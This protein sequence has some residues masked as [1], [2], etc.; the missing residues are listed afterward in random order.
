MRR[1][2]VLL[3]AM[4]IAWAS[5]AWSAN[6]DMKTLAGARGHFSIVYETVTTDDF[7]IAPAY[8]FQRMAFTQ[9]STLEIEVFA[10]DTKGYAAA[11]CESLGAVTAT[12]N[13]LE[14]KTGRQWL[15]IDV[16]TAETAGSVSYITI[17][18]NPQNAGAGG[19][20]GGGGGGGGVLGSGSIAEMTGYTGSKEVGD[21]WM[22]DNNDAGDCSTAAGTGT[23][24]CGWNG[25]SW[26]PIGSAGAGL[27]NI[28]EDL[29]PQL[30]GNLDGQ[31]NDITGLANLESKTQSSRLFYASAYAADADLDSINTYGIREALAACETAGGGRVVLPPGRTTMALGAGGICGV[32]A[33]TSP[34]IKLPAVNRGD[35][36]EVGSCE[37]V[38]FGSGAEEVG[39]GGTATPTDLR[40]TGI[41]SMT[42]TH[43]VRTL[44]QATAQGQVLRDF[45][46]TTTNPDSVTYPIWV[47]SDEASPGDTGI[48]FLLIENVK[49]RDSAAG[50]VGY[51]IVLTNTE[52]G[53]IRDVNIEQVGTGI[54]ID[55]PPTNA[56]C[57]ASTTPW[58]CCTGSGTGTCSGGR[59]NAMRIESTRIAS[60][61]TGIQIETRNACEAINL[62]GV[63]V[64]GN[65]SGG[66]TIDA[67]ADCQVN[68]FGGWWENSS[69]ANSNV[70]NNSANATYVSWGARYGG[71]ATYSF[72]QS[73]AHASNVLP[74]T[75]V[76]PEHGNQ[77]A[78][79]TGGKVRLISPSILQESGTRNL[80][81]NVSG[82]SLH[83][84]DAGQSCGTHSIRG[85][86]GDLCYEPDNNELYVCEA[87]GTATICN[88]AG[89]WIPL[90][91]KLDENYTWT[92]NHDIITT[93]LEIPNST[94]L[95]ATCAV[96]QV[97]MDTDATSGQRIHACESANTWVLQGDGGGSGGTPG[98]SDTQVQFNDGGSF[99]GDAG[100]V[101][102]KTT[103]TLTAGA[104]DSPAD[105]TDGGILTLKEGVDDGTD[106][107][108]VK[109]PDSGLS[110][111]VTHT[112]NAAGQFP[113]N[114][115]AQTFTECF[116]FYAPTDTIADSD[117][118]QSLWRAP[119]AITITEVWCETDTG[120]VN[121][122]LQIDDGTPADVMGTDLVCASTAVS[123]SSGLTGS[124]ADGD[125]LDLA[126]T[127][128]AS[129]PTRLTVCA[130]Y[131]YD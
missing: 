95:P 55:E 109:V 41:S 121:M 87:S 6:Y 130:E 76:A 79:V 91:P 118:V 81:A 52:K 115:V 58:D 37:L 117:D 104:Y 45:H 21:M 110:G 38:G 49:I 2:F 97:Y 44:I 99:G 30:G 27:A 56:A 90:R 53:T 42:A 29:S 101:Y 28:V 32:S 85:V 106:T 14:L 39:S 127:S 64:E 9:G 92:G 22:V 72:R 43:G 47:A 69:P 74:S 25:T 120:T 51:G 94:T 71:S 66:L 128:V 73:I 23:T 103:D 129:S 82:G 86:T 11:T 48:D 24:W 15:V 122:D 60:G 105:A 116:P 119:A 75:L 102:N 40:F 78:G 98:G 4:A 54:L 35:G 62:F 83:V 13:N 88:T 100:L 3:A 19:G 84:V 61:G 10:C 70:L 77:I 16:T 20:S 107:F 57:T 65:T 34:V 1:L 68:D 112:L 18:S 125:R 126:I 12:T 80:G 8:S 63:V 33:C 5:P 114:A 89:E 108:N 96:G 93:T 67:G 7:L 36:V 113:A 124:M 46:I 26:E 50:D 111:S 59:N 31:G 17:Q 123:D 131:T